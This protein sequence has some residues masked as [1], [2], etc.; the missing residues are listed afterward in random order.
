MTS[1][2]RRK[3]PTTV[4][5][6]STAATS[7]S[8][9]RRPGLAWA[10]A[11][12]GLLLAAAAARAQAP[13]P[14]REPVWT[15]TPPASKGAVL[16][17]AQRQ[18][19]G[20]RPPP[21]FRDL[22]EDTQFYQIQVDPPGPEVFFRLE[23]EAQLFERQ[24]QKDRDKKQGPFST[25]ADMFPEQ[26]PLSKDRYAGRQWPPLPMLVEP[27]Y[28]CHK[29]L[30]FQQLN[31]ERYGWDLG[32]IQPFVSL[33]YFWFDA[34]TLPYHLGSRPQCCHECSAGLC[35]PGDPVPYMI[36]PPEISTTGLM[37]EAATVVLLLVAFP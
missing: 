37:A 3:R 9:R 13:P 18:P 27:A 35:L 32:A 21:D 8:D 10:A 14:P 31:E 36:Y 2:S 12:L 30:L 5:A 6:P 34:A 7:A 28:V 20:V 4:R 33:G 15:P 22:H 29:R 19:P 24:R 25:T 11:A 26:V 17:A 1:P 16:Q 23:S